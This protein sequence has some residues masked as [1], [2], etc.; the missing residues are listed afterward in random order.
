M[1]FDIPK[2]HTYGMGVLAPAVY[3]PYSNLSL[4]DGL[5]FKSPNWHIWEKHLFDFP[6]IPRTITALIHGNTIHSYLPHIKLPHKLRK[7]NT[8]YSWCLTH[9]TRGFFQIPK[10]GNRSWEHFLYLWIM[11]YN[12]QGKAV[13]YSEKKF[14]IFP[15][16]V[17]DTSRKSTVSVR[18]SWRKKNTPQ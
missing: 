1:D 5:F 3:T 17:G 7:N 6:Q 11:S 13:I 9:W 2:I 14:L 15:C 10:R 16:K 12:N 4:R 18:P 8:W